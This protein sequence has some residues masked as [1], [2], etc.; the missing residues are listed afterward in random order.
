[1]TK[2]SPRDEPVV[3]KL[4]G[5]RSPPR[6]HNR[7]T[8]DGEIVCY[9]CNKKGHI[10]R[11]CP[12]KKITVKESTGANPKPAF[13]CAN[14]IAQDRE[15]EIEARRK[16]CEIV[17]LVNGTPVSIHRDSQC[18]Q[19]AVSADL[20]PTHRYLNETVSLRGITGPVSLPLAEI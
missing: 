9:A 13:K 7:T 6:Q 3:Q 10:A 1:M 8:Q 2:S 4:T 11:D 12:E 5:T 20:V 15:Q 19:T 18:T 16:K 14:N 17:G